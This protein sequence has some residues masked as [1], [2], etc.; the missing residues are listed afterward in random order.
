MEFGVCPLSANTGLAIL[1]PAGQGEA[2]IDA[3]GFD[4]DAQAGLGEGAGLTPL[5]NGAGSTV[6]Y[7]FVRKFTNGRPQDTNNNATDFVLVAADGQPL[8]ARDGGTV[9]TM[10]GAPGPQSMTSPLTSTFSAVRT[11][12]FDPTVTSSN[13]PNRVVT[14]ASG[15]TPGALE[16]RRR[17]T[18]TSTQAIS[19]IRF[20]IADITTDGSPVVISP[21]AILRAVSSASLTIGNQTTIPLTLEQTSGQTGGGLNAS[22]LAGTAD[23]PQSLAPGQSVF[24]NF[25]MNV[26][27]NGRFRF[28][29][30]VEAIQ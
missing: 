20:R 15:S 27:Q 19:R 26:V 5:A 24:V 7:S 10:L 17:I 6:Q 13:A 4:G 1:P 30:T 25:K 2:P 14:S 3:A 18:N 23:L 21:Q 22:I 8:P 16:I 9:P 12:L 29:V 28:I 11:S